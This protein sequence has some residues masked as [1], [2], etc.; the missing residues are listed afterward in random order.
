MSAL[1]L[2]TIV[3]FKLICIAGD[4]YAIPVGIQKTNRAVAGNFQCLR[5]ADNWNLSSF[6]NRVQIIDFVVG[7]DI[8]AKVMEFGNAV[9]AHCF[10]SLG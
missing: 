5:A 4:L 6:E 1:G 7:L 2:F 3:V 8:N 9:T 10:G